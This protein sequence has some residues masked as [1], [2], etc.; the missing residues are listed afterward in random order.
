MGDV[1][2]DGRLGIRR[3]RGSCDVVV[4]VIGCGTSDGMFD[5]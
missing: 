1:N 5:L 2:G 3:T 4:G